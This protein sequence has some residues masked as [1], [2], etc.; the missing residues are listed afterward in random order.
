MKPLT[1][2][3]KDKIEHFYY[4]ESLWVDEVVRKIYPRTTTFIEKKLKGRFQSAASYFLLNWMD[5][6]IERQRAVEYPDK[7]RM[8]KVMYIRQITVVVNRKGKEVAKRTFPVGVIIKNN[9]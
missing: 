6:K 7:N 2:I 8:R 3:N 1:R 4:E 5:L 9:G